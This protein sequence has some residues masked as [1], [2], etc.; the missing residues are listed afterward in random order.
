[1]PRRESAGMACIGSVGNPL[2]RATGEAIENVFMEEY[3]TWQTAALTALQSK[4]KMGKGK[5]KSKTAKPSM[6]CTWPC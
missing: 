6:V 3:M 4:Q 1:M 5:D 2:A